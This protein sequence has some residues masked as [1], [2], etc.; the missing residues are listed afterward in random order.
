MYITHSWTIPYLAILHNSTQLPLEN[1]L[2]CCGRSGGRGGSGWLGGA[3][4]LAAAARS[5]TQSARL[6]H[7]V[8][9]VP[10]RAL[11]VARLVGRLRWNVFFMSRCVH[12]VLKCYIYIYSYLLF[13]LCYPCS[14]VSCASNM[15][16]PDLSSILAGDLPLPSFLVTCSRFIVNVAEI[17]VSLKMGST[18][19]LQMNT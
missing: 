4:Q 16:C 3:L 17:W 14:F 1:P 19:Y 7:Q 18:T 5:A 12:M 8:F 2:R 15:S 13:V 11:G 6:T 9:P 10:W